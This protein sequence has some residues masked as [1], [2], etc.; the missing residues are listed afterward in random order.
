MTSST[1]CHQVVCLGIRIETLIFKIVLNTFILLCT[2]ISYNTNIDNCI[3]NTVI[4]DRKVEKVVYS[5][6]SNVVS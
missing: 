5:S 3:M 1:K 6:V 2:M 4:K